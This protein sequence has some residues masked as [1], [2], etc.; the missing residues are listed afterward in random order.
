MNKMELSIKVQN[1]DGLH[2][3]P[4]GILAKAISQF[5]SKVDLAIGEKKVNA[6]SIMSIMSL[7]L[8][9][10]DEVRFFAEGDD[11]SS[12]IEKIKNLFESNFQE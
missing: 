12:V 7:G 8:K 9:G 1:E 2:A 11:A 5:T 3:R 4:A 10:G 6:K